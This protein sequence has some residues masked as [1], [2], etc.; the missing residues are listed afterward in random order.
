MCLLLPMLLLKKRI[1]DVSLIEFALSGSVVLRTPP[2]PPPIAISQSSEVWTNG[3][4]CKGMT[5]ALTR[6][7]RLCTATAV[8]QQSTINRRLSG[9]SAAQMAARLLAVVVLWQ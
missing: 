3:R 5:Y 8:Q 9:V 2:P 7:I 6:F 1:A 4:Q